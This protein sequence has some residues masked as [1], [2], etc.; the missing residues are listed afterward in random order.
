MLKKASNLAPETQPRVINLKFE[1][2]FVYSWVA[3]TILPHTF[4]EKWH[5]RQDRRE[6]I[7]HFRLGYE[8]KY[9]FL[10]N[11]KPFFV[12]TIISVILPQKNFIL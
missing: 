9:I 12:T 1:A 3:Y 7:C 10:S 2:F 4:S 6:E 8:E 5:L 11:E